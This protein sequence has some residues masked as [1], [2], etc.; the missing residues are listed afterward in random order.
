[1]R[2]LETA[3][4]LATLLALSLATSSASAAP[5]TPAGAC[6]A[7]AGWDDPSP[8][9]HVFGNTWYASVPAASPRCW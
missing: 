3:G 1:M 7:D 6:P 9:V 8:P 4:A 2:L 5:A